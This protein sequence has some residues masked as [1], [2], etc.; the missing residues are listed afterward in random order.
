MNPRGC[1]INWVHPIAPSYSQSHSPSAC[2]FCFVQFTRLNLP[3]SPVLPTFKHTFNLGFHQFFCLASLL[4]YEGIFPSK[5]WAMSPDPEPCV[6][7]YP[8]SN[9]QI[10]NT[11]LHFLLERIENVW[12]TKYCWTETHISTKCY[13][14]AK[15]GGSCS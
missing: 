5:V 3:V 7:I 9:L 4:Y 15:D 12:P 8:S 14:Q 1:A 6:N 13:S 10:Q 2:L 11:H